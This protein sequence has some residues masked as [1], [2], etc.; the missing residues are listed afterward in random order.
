MRI[1]VVQ[2]SPS[3]A[4]LDKNISRATALLADLPQSQLDL[5]ILPELSFTG[6]NF[7][8]P[9]SIAPFVETRTASPSREWAKRIARQYC[10]TVIVGLPTQDTHRRNTA[11]VV[12]SEGNVV[13]EYS[14]HFMFD[15]DLK[16]GCTPGPGFD[17]T[18]LQFNTNTTNTNNTNNTTNT[19]NTNNNNANEEIPTNTSIGICMDINPKEFIAP[20]TSYEYANYVLSQTQQ[21]I[22]LII[23]P[24]AWLLSPKE[25][26]STES[27]LFTLE[28]W[29][30][31]L[32]PL[33][34]DSKWRTVIICNRTGEEDGGAVYAGTSCVL[35]IGGGGQVVIL[36]MLGREEGV[37]YVDLEL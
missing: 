23:L 10:S 33:V 14:K 29:I 17:F 31:R 20:F 18:T 30:K 15:T 19:N 13:Y 27:S 16:W 8:T 34:Q 11:S 4:T 25:P 21:H 2:T 37:L 35:R 28:Y 3:L 12:N 36:G 9:S 32:Y 7:Q 1:A 24:M 22:S 6:Y 5:I 26:E